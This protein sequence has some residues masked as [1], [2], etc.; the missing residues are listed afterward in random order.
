MIQRVAVISFKIMDKCGIVKWSTNSFKVTFSLFAI[1]LISLA[2]VL[3]C[4]QI[5]PRCYAVG[6]PVNIIGVFFF[7][8]C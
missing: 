4:L 1:F 5:P 6:I 3:S 7:V 8:V 2:F